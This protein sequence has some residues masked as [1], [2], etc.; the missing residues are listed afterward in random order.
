MKAIAALAGLLALVVGGR[1]LHPTVV[2][3][4]HHDSWRA[5]APIPPQEILPFAVVGLEPECE[6]EGGVE[7]QRPRSD[8]DAVV[9]AVEGQ[10]DAGDA[11]H[12]VGGFAWVAA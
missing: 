1:G 5:G 12:T 6:G 8:A 2:K 4:Q 10:G 9:H 11:R 7:V 3:D